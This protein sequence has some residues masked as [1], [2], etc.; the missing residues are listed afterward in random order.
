MD[1]TV[2]DRSPLVGDESEDN[3]RAYLSRDRKQ[4]QFTA[5]GRTSNTG[6][7][8]VGQSY[9]NPRDRNYIPVGYGFPGPSETYTQI[10]THSLWRRID[11]LFLPQSDATSRIG[12]FYVTTEYNSKTVTIPIIKMSQDGKK[13]PK[14][15]TLICP[16]GSL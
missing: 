12:V 1:V 6:T 5:I 4:A 15:E 14:V 10:L 16:I 8:E 3:Y 2:F 7:F 13:F 9:P 11:I